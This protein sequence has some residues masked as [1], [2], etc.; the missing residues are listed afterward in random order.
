[1]NVSF[2]LSLFNGC[3]TATESRII[4]FLE[5]P[6]ASFTPSKNDGF[7]NDVITF[8]VNNVSPIDSSFR[9]FFGIFGDR[10]DGNP[11]QAQSVQFTQ[12]GIFPVELRVTNENGCI[13]TS[14]L[15]IGIIRNQLIFVPN[16]FS[17]TAQKEEN[18]ALRVFGTNVSA[19]DFEFSVYNR[20]GIQVFTTNNLTEAQN[21]GW[22]GRLE[23]AADYEPVGVYTY[24]I[25]GKYFDGTPFEK[26]GNSTL[27]R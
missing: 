26:I 20:W 19:Q 6:D 21:I 23:G 16:V 14:R 15:E 8:T 9:W 3:D 12:F 4:I 22:T 11:P 27:I 17:P 2:N 18:R 5:G 24:F 1:L 7:L 25:K 10:T 13:D